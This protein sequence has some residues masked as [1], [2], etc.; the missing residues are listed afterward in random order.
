MGEQGQGFVVQFVHRPEGA[1]AIQAEG[2][3][4]V[5]LG[6]LAQGGDGQAG[7]S[8]E[9]GDRGVSARG[10]G[11]AQGAG[12]G[13]GQA[14]DEP[15]AQ[16]EAA[17]GVDG[18]VELRAVGVNRQYN[19]AVIGGVAEDLGRGVEAH[20]LAVDERGGE[21]G[22]VVAFEPGGGVDQQGEAGGVAF[23]E[24][25]LAEALDLLEA[26]LGEVQWVA[27]LGHASDDLAAE[28]VDDLLA[29][30]PGG[31]GA[32]ELVGLV[33][34]EA[35][36][37]DGQGHGLFLEER[38]A[39]GLAEDGA[40]FV[41]RETDGLQAVAAAE[42]GVDHVALDGAGADDG[43]FDDQVVEAAG[44][45]AREHGHLGAGLDLEDADGVGGADHVVDGGVFGGDGG[46]G[47]RWRV[48]GP[49]LM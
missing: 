44:P 19:D 46:E 31:D 29:G 7:T 41:I 5:G 30:L 17:A 6:E 26:A 47:E 1:L 33:G 18:A 13:L 48:G 25:V 34:G 45:Q 4:G 14:G 35:G 10:A 24:A 40:D 20:G 37:D 32:A 38:D 11:G 22:G 12:V 27:A 43:D 39:E 9:G 49:G 21:V 2:A 8:P 28:V 23:G 3:E 15:Q 16:A 36:G 42:V